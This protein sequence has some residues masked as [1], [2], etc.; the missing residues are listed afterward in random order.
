M[1]PELYVLLVHDTNFY[2]KELPVNP[3]N[4]EV[5]GYVR[6]L[7]VGPGY[8]E[9]MLTVSDFWLLPKD[10]TRLENSTESVTV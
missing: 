4:Q 10:Y 7:N 2:P 8:F 6:D 9:P 5:V 3:L 1:K